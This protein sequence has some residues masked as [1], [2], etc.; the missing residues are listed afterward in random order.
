LG[1]R[2]GKGID[3]KRDR[4][5]AVTLFMTGCALDDA[6][7]CMHSGEMLLS[8]RGLPVDR[9]A[10]RRALDRACDL[11]SLEG[12]RDLKA[13]AAIDDAFDEVVSALERGCSLGDRRMCKAAQKAALR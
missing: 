2:L 7:S 12:C 13:A 3:V 8:G 11:G 10:G 1:V 6:E 4:A 9:D 5:E